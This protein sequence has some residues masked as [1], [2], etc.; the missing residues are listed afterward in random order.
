MCS[1]GTL[2][3]RGRIWLPASSPVVVDGNAWYTHEIQVIANGPTPGSFVWAWIDKGGGP[4]EARPCEGGE[5]GGGDGGDG[6]GGGTDPALVARV[7]ELEKRL[8]ELEA[9]AVK[10]G[11]TIGLES[12]G[13]P[14]HD[15]QGKLLCA[16]AGGPT[17]DHVPFSLTSRPAA[18]KAGP[19]ESWKVRE[20][21]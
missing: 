11:D 16:E 19:W 5:S 20:G 8:A 2:D 12:W 1:S 9:A 10:K 7:E 13:D 18:E 17:R 6:G 15:R 21:Q 14:E 4:Y 3:P